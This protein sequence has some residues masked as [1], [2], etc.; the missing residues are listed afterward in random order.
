M[1]DVGIPETPEEELI[2]LLRSQRAQVMG[3]LVHG[4]MLLDQLLTEMRLANVTPSAQVIFSKA[5]FDRQIRMLLGA[6]QD[7]PDGT[8]GSRPRDCGGI[9]G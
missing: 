6:K 4:M 7:D 8:P 5:E 1:T 9:T 3:I 2:L